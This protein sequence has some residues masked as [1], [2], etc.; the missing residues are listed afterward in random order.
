[1]VKEGHKGRGLY[2]PWCL[3]KGLQEVP[4]DWEGL[5]AKG[6]VFPAP[7]LSELGA[8]GKVLECSHDDHISD[9]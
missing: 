6:D 9:V 2:C 5:G 7:R 3:C 4:G 1:M 8:P